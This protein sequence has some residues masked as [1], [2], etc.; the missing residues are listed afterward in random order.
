MFRERA[1]V[2]HD[3]SA[4]IAE[5]SEGAFDGPPSFIAAPR[6]AILGRRLAPILALRGD[7]LD[8]APGQ[9]LA[10]RVA[11]VAAVGDEADRLLPGTSSPRPSP[12]SDRPKRRLHE[13]DLRR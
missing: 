5:P 8:A 3:E 10:Q 1:M 12:Y 7:Q 13:L 4:E 2:G 9:L 11:I 6:P